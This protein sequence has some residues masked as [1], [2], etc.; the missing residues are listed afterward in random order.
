M[1]DDP[2]AIKTRSKVTAINRVAGHGFRRHQRTRRSR[3]EALRARIG[4]SSRNRCKSSASAA[5]VGY[6]CAGSRAIA[7]STIVSRSFGTEGATVFSRD[8]DS[9]S[10][11]C[12]KVWRSAAS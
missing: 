3:C 11:R 7:F 1:V 10:T 5:A 6:R 12:I 8:G 9:L 2:T 4:L